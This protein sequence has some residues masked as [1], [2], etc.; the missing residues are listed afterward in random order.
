MTE[1]A[2]RDVTQGKNIAM[3][4]KLVILIRIIQEND[5][6]SPKTIMIGTL[7]IEK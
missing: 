6:N 1:Y 5:K 2:T 4:K 3:R 7:T